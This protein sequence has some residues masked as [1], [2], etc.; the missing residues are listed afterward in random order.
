MTGDTPGLRIFSPEWINT[1]GGDIPTAFRPTIASICESFQLGG[2]SDPSI[3]YAMIRP[4]IEGVKTETTD[5]I[6]EPGAFK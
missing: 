3:L 4:L 6:H 1:V 5:D 2:S